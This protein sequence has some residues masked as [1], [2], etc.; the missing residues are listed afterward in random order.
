VIGGI[1]SLVGAGIAWLYI[2]RR[3]A[4]K[5]SERIRRDGDS[6]RRLAFLRI[7]GNV[8]HENWQG[9]ALVVEPHRAT[10]IPEGWGPSGEIVLETLTVRG[11]RSPDPAEVWSL[12]PGLLV[13]DATSGERSVELAVNDETRALLERLCG[14]TERLG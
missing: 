6:A 9:G 7:H 10:W 5:Q 11:T 13:V 2:T 1:A 14:E 12:Q 4:R 3:R 8:L